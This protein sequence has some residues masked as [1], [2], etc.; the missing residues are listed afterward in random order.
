MLLRSPAGPRRDLLDRR[1]TTAVVIGAHGRRRPA[2][3][4]AGRVTTA[5]CWSLPPSCADQLGRRLCGWAL[6]QPGDAAARTD[7]RP[8]RRRAAGRAAGA[9]SCSPPTGPACGARRRCA[10]GCS[11]SASCPAPSPRSPAWSG[12]PWSCCPGWSPPAPGCSSASTRS[13]STARA[14]CGWPRCRCGP[15][16]CSGP[17]AQVVAETCAIAV[18]LTVAAG[19]LRA[20]RPPTAGEAA[21]LAACAVVVVLR[22]VATCME[23]SVTRPHRADLPGPRDTPAPPGR[24]GR[25]LRAAGGVDHPGRG[26]VLDAG[27]GGSVARGRSPVA[28]PVL[29]AE[30]APAGSGVAALGGRRHPGPRGRRPSPA[31]DRHGDVDHGT[32]TAGNGPKRLRTGPPLGSVR[33]ARTPVD[34]HRC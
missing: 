14:R 32:R 21:A 9:A 4:T 19:S 30:R 33:C 11:S 8:V 6:R 31:A 10:A 23:L 16:R 25:L 26:P 20:E 15:A 28:R 29:P 13:A 2:S 27:G 22:V 1:P 3:S 18:V 24:H 7:A 5:P 17:R 34:R 12:R